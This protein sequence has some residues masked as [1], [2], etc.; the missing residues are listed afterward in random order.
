MDL[1]NQFEEVSVC[2]HC[3]ALTE[4]KFSG[5]EGWTFCTD[6]CGC[7]EGDRIEHKFICKYCEEIK[8][9]E[10]CETC[11]SITL[12][13]QE[14]KFGC[15]IACMAMI[16]NKTYQELKTMLP[17]NRG[18]GDK[19]G[20]D[21]Q[22]QISFLFTQGFIGMTVYACE[23]HTQRKRPP[24]EWVKPLAPINIVTCITE[25]GPHAILW[26]QGRVYDPNKSG[27]FSIK[28]Y[29]VQGITGFWNLSADGKN[30]I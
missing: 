29:D 25:N 4:E 9:T 21:S 26:V 11:I 16:L 27:V 22:D 6:G 5:D 10:H 17:S 12:I 3:G 19:N 8:D 20:M 2:P 1:S 24:E 15:A 18:Y 23:S 7:L 14:E 30:L 13:K 28:D